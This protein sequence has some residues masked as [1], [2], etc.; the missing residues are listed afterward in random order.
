M[1][2]TMDG[3]EP[4]DKTRSL[5]LMADPTSTTIAAY[6]GLRSRQ[7]DAEGNVHPKAAAERRWPTSC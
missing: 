7:Q 5:G 3:D 1:Q 6:A 2:T 4:L